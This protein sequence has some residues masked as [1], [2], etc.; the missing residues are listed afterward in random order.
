MRN[1]I[2]AVLLYLSWPVCTVSDIWKNEP[3]TPVS[4]IIF[5]KTV[6]Q[7]FR[8]YY[9]ANQLWLSA[10]FVLVGWLVATT[11]TRTL[12]ILLWANLL[13]SLIDLVNY[14]LYFRR[15]EWFLRAEFMVMLIATILIFYYA[16][17]TNKNEKTS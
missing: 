7:D 10:V 1:R 5:D 12:R 16:S 9:I 6:L 3:V 17:T 14:W 15:Q 13:I 2:A 4:W 8:W 11:K